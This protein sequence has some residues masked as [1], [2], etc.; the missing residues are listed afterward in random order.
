MTQPAMEPAALARSTIRSVVFS[1]FGTVWPTAIALVT[2]PFIY[3]R[4]GAFSFGLWT[5]AGTVYGFAGLLELGIGTAST[6]H[7]AA[8]SERPDGAR[9]ASLYFENSL[10]F[11]LLLGVVMGALLLG[12][13]PQAR[14][15]LA[16]TATGDDAQLADRCIRAMGVAF[17][18]V[19]LQNV[20]IA[21][22]SAYR[23]YGIIQL[24]LGARA[25]ATGLAALFVLPNGGGVPSLILVSGA[26]SIVISCATLAFVRARLLR[27]TIIP[28]ISRKH[29][30][31]LAGFGGYM[32]AGQIAGYVKTSADRLLLSAL[33]GPAVAGNY[34][35]PHGLASRLHGLTSSALNVIFPS[36]SALSARGDS[37]SERV[38]YEKSLA[39]AS[40]IAGT[41]AMP[42][43]VLGQPFLALW[44]SPEF[45]SRNHIVLSV[46]VFAFYVLALAV[47][48]YYALIGR[49]LVR[50]TMLY[51]LVAC[52]VT[53]GIAAAAIPRFGGLGAGLALLLANTLQMAGLVRSYERQEERA[54][55]WWSLPLRAALVLSAGVALKM[56]GIDSLVHGW[57][58]LIAMSAVTG[59]GGWALMSKL[60]LK[61]EDRVAART[62][63]WRAFRRLPVSS[64]A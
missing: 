25:T 60:L 50:T 4:T 42:L 51:D 53:V 26:L 23:R 14:A 45:A 29:F 16:R 62:L 13:A 20:S 15:I 63:V 49:G 12:I 22:M 28:R 40:A 6:H 7:I 39:F 46:L 31:E 38:L 1:L 5:L 55:K 34:S 2:T 64:G 59:I 61:P 19:M 32:F 47:V 30:L 3:H 56:A 9:D 57:P 18:T 54:T 21:T 36:I 33:L 24:S 44:I 11:Y 8:C 52:V 58:S 35:V 27:F 37:R 43:L 10:A 17:P 48:P 41:I